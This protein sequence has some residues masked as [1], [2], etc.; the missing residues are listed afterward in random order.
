MR[1]LRLPVV[2]G[3]ENRKAVR[4]AL[5]RCGGSL[6]HLIDPDPGTRA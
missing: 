4:L 6:R 3:A 1:S 5:Y 2:P